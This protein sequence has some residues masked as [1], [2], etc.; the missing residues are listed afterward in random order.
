MEIKVICRRIAMKKWIM[1]LFLMGQASLSFA[2]YGSSSGQNY[3]PNQSGRSSQSYGNQQ[4]SSGSPCENLKSTDPEAY[5]FSQQLSPIHQSVFCAQF[6]KAQQKQAMA[7]AGSET[8]D[9]QGKSSGSITPDMAVE[10]VMQTA[11][12]QQ[13]NSS[14]QGSQSSTQQSPYSSQGQSSS[15]RSGRYSNY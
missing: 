10:V 9:I 6:S 2:Q 1:L 3:N 11:R 12:Y 8:Q 13:G 15:S 5:A 4:S 14:T 7:L